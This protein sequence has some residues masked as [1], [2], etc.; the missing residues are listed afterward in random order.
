MGNV[1]FLPSFQHF[2]ILFFT[3]SKERQMDSRCRS[4]LLGPDYAERSAGG[5]FL[6]L[7]AHILLYSTSAGCKRHNVLS[8]SQHSHLHFLRASR[9]R[10]CKA[11]T[12]EQHIQAHG[13]KGKQELIWM[14][15]CCLKIKGLVMKRVYWQGA[16]R[17]SLRNRVMYREWRRA[18]FTV[19]LFL[20]NT[21]V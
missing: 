9:Q 20:P 10:L 18:V 6:L 14:H 12:F 15:L 16:A 7:P 5:V 4:R 11:C 8:S 2:H 3:L 21:T 17:T 1:S 19:A 13:S